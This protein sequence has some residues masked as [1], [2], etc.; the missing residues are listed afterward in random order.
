MSKRR[1][2]RGEAIGEQIIEYVD[3]IV[4]LF[5]GE[6]PGV[7]LSV[8]ITAGLYPDGCLHTEVFQ[9]SDPSVAEDIA[10][11]LKDEGALGEDTEQY[12]LGEEDNG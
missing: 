10:K 2:L 4:T 11:Q 1:R 12:P 9:F 8:I 3:R 6:K 5:S 7:Q